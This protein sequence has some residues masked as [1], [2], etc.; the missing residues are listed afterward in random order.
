MQGL[1]VQAAVAAVAV[2][3]VAVAEGVVEVGGVEVCYRYSPRST[4]PSVSFL[5]DWI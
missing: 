3:A 2:A 5:N 1:P 4:I